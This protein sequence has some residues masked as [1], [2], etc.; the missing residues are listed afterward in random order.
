MDNYND[1]IGLQNTLTHQHTFR[2]QPKTKANQTNPQ[3]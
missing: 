2:N 3:I 1:K